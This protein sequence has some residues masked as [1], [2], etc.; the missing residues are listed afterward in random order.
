MPITVRGAW[1]LRSASLVAKRPALIAAKP[2]SWAFSGS[3][4]L[5]TASK[6]AR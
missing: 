1:V 4:E 6:K 2:R 3:M 5:N